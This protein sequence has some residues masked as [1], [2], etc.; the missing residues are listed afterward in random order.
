MMHKSKQLYS[1][2]LVLLMA[3]LIVVSVFAPTAYAAN[4]DGDHRSYREH[5]TVIMLTGRDAD[6]KYEL[7]PNDLRLLRIKDAA[8]GDTFY[9]S[10]QVENETD[11]E[12][13][14][15]V[16]S[17]TNNL[18]HDTAL[19]DVLD[20][21]I[22]VAGES[23]YSG[24]YAAK[25]TPVTDYYS[26]RPGETLVFDIQVLFPDFANNDY[27]GKQMDSTWTFD[28]VFHKPGDS[29]PNM[30]DPF[31]EIIQTGRNYT[32]SNTTLL[33]ALFL[34]IFSGTALFLTFV[35][36][37]AAKRT[38]RLREGRGEAATLVEKED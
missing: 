22:S 27:Q 29:S 9:G 6:G 1:Q 11:A 32:D 30:K 18:V 36:Y 10:V 38:Q 33:T 4:Q 25:H 26:I 15:S 24:S 17:I 2:W 13:A 7:H 8:P 5:N 28:A 14:V 21:S 12:M 3:V 16:H 23:A 35:R 20:L 34:F 37:R 31:D 19:F